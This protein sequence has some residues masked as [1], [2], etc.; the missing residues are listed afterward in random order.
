V[1]YSGICTFG[2]VGA[3]NCSGLR[4]GMTGVVSTDRLTG[5]GMRLDTGFGVGMRF[6]IGGLLGLR[7][8]W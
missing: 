1:S 8:W 3:V 4:T 6:G 7:L 2:T 5:P